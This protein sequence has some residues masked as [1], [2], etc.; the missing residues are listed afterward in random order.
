MEKEGSL[1]FFRAAP[2]L[3]LPLPWIPE[4]WFAA[5]TCQ[6]STADPLSSSCDPQRALQWTPGLQPLIGSFKSPACTLPHCTLLYPFLQVTIVSLPCKSLSIYV[7]YIKSISVVKRWLI[8]RVLNKN[9]LKV[10]S[11]CSFVL[12]S[13]MLKELGRKCFGNARNICLE[14]SILVLKT[15]RNTEE[16]LLE[17][18]SN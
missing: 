2:V 4:S 8:T 15:K 14:T 1:L 7:S 5:Q 13:R 9:N 12:G 11:L 16:Q 18:E 6:P 3:P 10:M 17:Q